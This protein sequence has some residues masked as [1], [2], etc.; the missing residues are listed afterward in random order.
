MGRHSSPDQIPFYRSAAGW[1]L[2]WVMIAVVIGVA[3]WTAVSAVGSED[4]EAPPPVE[5]RSPRTERPDRSP[6]PT[7]SPTPLETESPEPDEPDE[8]DE[9]R[10]E[11]LTEGVTVQVLNGTNDPDAAV[12]L[13]NRL[14]DLGF[15]IVAVNEA[16]KLY[17]ETTVFWSS[18]ASREAAERL[19][20]RFDWVAELKPANLSDAA[21][22]HVVV[23]QDRT[24]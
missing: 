1:F 18:D 15:E 9:P 4:F 16:S 10:V 12:A 13:S 23:G 24:S 22:L 5:T 8:P 19:A 3:L 2:P 7:E 11:L 20:E 6:S 14:S 21:S 17:S